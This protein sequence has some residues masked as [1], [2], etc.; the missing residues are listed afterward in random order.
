MYT[1]YPHSRGQT[2]ITGTQRNHSL[3]FEPGFFTDPHYIDLKKQ[4][5][6]YKKHREVI[7]RT[8]IYQ[9]EL[10]YGHTKFSPS[11]PAKCVESNSVLKDAGKA[12]DL[13]DPSEDDQAIGQ[14]PRENTQI[15]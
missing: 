14:C 13:L 12:K 6:A 1:A 5:W 11:S 4:I 2:H 10:E 7:R 8:D 3:N 15:A 9:G